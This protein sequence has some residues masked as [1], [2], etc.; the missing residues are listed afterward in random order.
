MTIQISPARLLALVEPVKFSK[1]EWKDMAYLLKS[2]YEVN[3][4]Y[5]ERVIIET[6]DRDNHSDTYR[7]MRTWYHRLSDYSKDFDE[8]IRMIDYNKR[9]MNEQYK[10]ENNENEIQNTNPR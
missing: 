1:E 6:I 5:F 8:L 4:D 3:T 2:E 7:T 9:N 10:G